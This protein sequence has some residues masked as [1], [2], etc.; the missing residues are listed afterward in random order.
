MGRVRTLALAAACALTAACQAASDG[1]TGVGAP[2]ADAP[3]AYATAEVD[4]RGTLKL[5]QEIAARFA[6]EVPPEVERALAADGYDCGPNPAAPA[7]RACLAVRRDGACEV[8]DVVRV[9]PFEAYKTQ[10]IRICP[11]DAGKPA[12]GPGR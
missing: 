10:T 7:E 8:H 9:A 1:E 11:T 12:P 4:P 6:G 3:D 5:R 2:E